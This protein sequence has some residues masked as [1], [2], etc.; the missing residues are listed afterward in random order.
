LMFERYHK[1]LVGGSKQLALE[2]STLRLRS[3]AISTM[4]QDFGPADSS[5]GL[6]LG[7]EALQDARER[8]A[9]LSTE[10]RET[11]EGERRRLS[12][13]QA[14]IE[15]SQ[16]LRQRLWEV[17]ETILKTQ[18]SRDACPLCHTEFP[19]GQLALRMQAGLDANLEGAALVVLSRVD[20]LEKDLAFALRQEKEISRLMRFAE[21]VGKDPHESLIVELVELRTSLAQ[22]LETLGQ[23][24]AEIAAD[25][26][27][28]ETQGLTESDLF[29]VE[30]WLVD[31][32][33]KL[34]SS[35]EESGREVRERELL[36]GRLAADRGRIASELANCSYELAALL[37]A[38]DTD[39][40]EIRKLFK[41]QVEWIDA[42]QSSLSGLQSFAPQFAIPGARPL[43]DLQVELGEL[44]ERAITIQELERQETTAQEQR[45]EAAVRKALVEEKLSSVTQRGKAYQNAHRAL[46]RIRE[47][48]SL[49]EA[50]E[51]S[52]KK[53]RA[54]IESIFSQIHSPDEFSGIGARLG[55]LV[56]RVDGSDTALSEISTGQRAAYALSLFLAQNAQLRDGP[57][58]LLIDDPVAHV[59]DMN[60]L[61]L[62]DYLREVV[63]QTQRQIFFATASEKIAALF[64][65]KFDFLGSPDFC[66]FDIERQ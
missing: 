13:L 40:R 60:F 26:A 10:L 49:N 33:F 58:V 6:N 51:E 44:R 12:G 42:V 66:R 46:N 31:A 43:A 24:S 25:L 37:G 54:A 61:S 64:E 4:L 15:A 16:L 22:E 28:L 23:R 17:A 18:E 5:S 21:R 1:H 7:S 55:R 62:L 9:K 35:I 65:R 29:E 34:P 53:N 19:P 50:V 45:R 27:E 2:A 20:S 56:R 41:A 3:E 32:K 59:D 39:P 48:H 36:V 8:V 47:E 63:I 38:Q 52:L 11:L 30:G 14:S 57:P